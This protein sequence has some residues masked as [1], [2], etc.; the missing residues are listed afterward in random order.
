MLHGEHGGL[1]SALLNAG[2]LHLDVGDLGMSAREAAQA[3][4]IAE[5]HHNVVLRARACTLMGMIENARV[6]ELLGSAEEIPQYARLA[7]QHCMEA[8]ALAQSMEN[9]RV[10]LNA[11]VALGE[12]AANNFFHDYELAQRCVDAASALLEP[13][14]A[15]YAVEELNALKAR[16]LKVVGIEDTLRAW[17]QGIITGKSFQE[18]TEQFAQ[19][20]IPRVWMREECKISRVAKKL[21]MS[22]QKVRRL[23]KRSSVA[24]APVAGL[25]KAGL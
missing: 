8:V 3:L 9:K 18:V 21:A 10:L 12:T 19:L 20:V 25:G 14:D 15:D 22:P 4:E 16:L 5:A 23:V 6:E 1:G 7:K 24:G 13:Q 11:Y 17:S 2:Y